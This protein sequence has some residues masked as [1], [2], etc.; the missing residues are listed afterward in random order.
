MWQGYTQALQGYTDARA[1]DAHKEQPRG[2]E[3]L[4]RGTGLS[5]FGREKAG[6]VVGGEGGE[7]GG[8]RES[9]GRVMVEEVTAGVGG[10]G[11]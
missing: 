5:P 11:G 10:G 9:G 4:R 8:L 2:T 1:L 7:R 3:L 6:A